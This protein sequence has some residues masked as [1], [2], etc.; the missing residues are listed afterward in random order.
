MSNDSVVQ[1]HDINGN[2]IPLD[3]DSVDSVV[4]N[5]DCMELLRA[6]PDKCI[7]LAIVDPPYGIAAPKGT[8]LSRAEGRGK[9]SGTAELVRKRAGSLKGSGK[10]KNRVLNISDTDWDNT[11]PRRNI[12]MSCSEFQGIRSSG[13]ATILAFLRQDALLSGIN[14]SRGRISHRRNMHGQATACQARSSL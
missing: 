14:V 7:D 2:T 3:L 11:P 4:F 5:A 6:L 13:A 8:Y 1:F 12:L 10:L 9:Y